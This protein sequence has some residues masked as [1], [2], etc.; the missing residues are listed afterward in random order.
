MQPDKEDASAMLQKAIEHFRLFRYCQ[1]TGEQVANLLAM[2]DALTALPEH[3]QTLERL[4]SE[5]YTFLVDVVKSGDAIAGASE[6][7]ARME[8]F[9]Y[10]HPDKN[11]L[12]P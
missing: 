1:F 12:A 7:L 9:D 8:R 2:G 4:R 11:R 5:F 6:A 3:S 10:A